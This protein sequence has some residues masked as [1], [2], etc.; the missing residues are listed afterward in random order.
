MSSMTHQLV[1]DQQCR[2]SSC[3]F[4][5]SRFYC[6]YFVTRTKAQN[7]SGECL[8]VEL[9]SP[10]QCA[11]FN[12][13]IL[14][15][16]GVCKTLWI[17]CAGYLRLSNDMT[18]HR[19]KFFQIWDHIDSGHMSLLHPLSLEDGV[20]LHSPSRTSLSTHI[21]IVHLQ[22]AHHEFESQRVMELPIEL[23]NEKS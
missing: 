10:E 5:T 6:K 18:S 11:K 4:R 19:W 12:I 13:N 20:K 15:E 8:I 23:L 16:R 14:V 2:V 7:W 3:I 1:C 22:S 21:S 9:S 17:L